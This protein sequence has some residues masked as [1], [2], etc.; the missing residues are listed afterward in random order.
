MGA[1][2]T[3]TLQ[4][5]PA[6]AFDTF[7]EELRS[8]LVV[9]GIQFETGPDGRIVEG[10]REIASVLSWQPGR[11]I[12]FDWHQLEWKKEVAPTLVEFRFEPNGDETRLI[13]TYDRWEYLFDDRGSEL[14]GWFAG[15][16]AAPLL[17]AMTPVRFEDWITDRAARRPSGHKA[18][19]TYRDPLYHRPNFLAILDILHLRPSD[20]L[21]EVGCGGGAFL[22][23]ALRHNCRAA[24]IDHS[25]EMVHLARDVN[26]EAM[27]EGRLV[28]VEAEVD[29]LPYSDSMFTCAVMTGVFSFLQNPVAALR[30]I[31][32]VLTKGGR[33]VVFTG[34]KEL[35]GTPAAP[36]PI[37]SRLNFY[38]DDELWGLA[39]EAGF[40]TVRVERPNLESFARQ[41]GVPLEHQH[42][43]SQ[44]SGQFLIAQK[45]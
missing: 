9:R 22:K 35:R 18:R 45:N 2:A 44:R 38:E 7:V 37:A 17:Q 33:L 30:E 12:V 4:T 26:H 41:A 15:Q 23:D 40:N 36:E 19:A 24:A 6:I 21:L 16:V 5:E 39:R 34:S 27:R 31:Y 42:L 43:F 29:W 25:R 8:A 3:I 13:L 11:K 20:Y 32:R 28:I 10:G 14:V 1:S